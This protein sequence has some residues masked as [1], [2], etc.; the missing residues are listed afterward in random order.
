MS[1]I[2]NDK[3]DQPEDETP[4]AAPEILRIPTL[5][6]KKVVTFA[7]VL[8]G[9]GVLCFCY[10]AN[11]AGLACIGAAMV[12]QYLFFAIAPFFLKE[13]VTPSA[14]VADGDVRYSRDRDSGHRRFTYP[15][16]TVF[17]LDS[18]GNLVDVE[19]SPETST[20]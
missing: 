6:V 15:D 4:L 5:W 8:L 1:K 17:V 13:K 3:D 14:C 9:I 16:G 18:K 7:L 19:V 10:G 11:L 20:S 12:G 2:G